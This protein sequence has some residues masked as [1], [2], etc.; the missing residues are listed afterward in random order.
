MNDKISKE[1]RDLIESAFSSIT[2]NDVNVPSFYK[3]VFNF[4]GKKSFLVAQKI[5]KQTTNPNALIYDPFL[6][7]DH[8]WLL[9]RTKVEK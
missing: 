8:S 3:K 9:R 1:T 5:I 2:D 6:D 7:Q 4:Q